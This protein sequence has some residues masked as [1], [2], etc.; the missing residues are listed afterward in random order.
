[1]EKEKYYY[2]GLEVECVNTYN[3]YDTYEL[4]IEVEVILNDDEG[5]IIEM[6]NDD[7]SNKFDKGEVARAIDLKTKFDNC[8]EYIEDIPSECYIF[9]DEDALDFLIKEQLITKNK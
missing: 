3:Q 1:M 6:I 4:E 2:K 5:D 9:D 7:G 8:N